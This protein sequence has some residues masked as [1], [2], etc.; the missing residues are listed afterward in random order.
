[1]IIDVSY[2]QKGSLYIPNS[3]NI[4]A[5]SSPNNGG[6]IDF[7]IKKYERELLMNALGVTLYNELQ[8][9]LGDIDNVAYAKWKALVNGEDYTINSKEYRYDGLKGYEKQSVIAFFVF[10]QYM[11]NDESV[12]TTTGTAK[13]K[14]KGA[15]IVSMTPKY[16]KV[17]NSFIEAYQK[18]SI[19]NPNVIVNR[20]GSFGL[21][22]FGNDD[23]Q[24]SLYQYLC[25]KNEL[26]E[27][28]FPDFMF[29]SYEVENSLGF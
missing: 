7:F 27:N 21:D 19:N 10:M 15:E 22:Y 20:S 26:D 8:V 9:A 6:E 28:N 24:R 13:N 4:S 18:P 12:Y 11:R 14:A 29:K 25:D 2:F 3:V 16:I 23:A 17:Q 5:S 1:M